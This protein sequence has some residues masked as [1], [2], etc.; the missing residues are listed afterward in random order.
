MPTAAPA[1]PPA[2]STPTAPAAP[3]IPP[4]APDKQPSD[5]MGDIMGD[6]D[7]LDKG[8]T[9]PTPPKAAPPPKP[10]PDAGKVKAPEAPPAPEKAPETPAADKPPETPPKPVR[11]AEL[12]TAYENLKKEANETLR[13]TIQRLEARVKELEAA[14]ADVKPLQEKL[15]AI[16]KRN[17]ELEQHL[18]FVDYSKSAEFQ[19]KYE[20][21]FASAWTRAVHDFSQLSV[22]IP[23]GE[24]D[25]G[26]PKFKTRAATADDLLALANMPLSQ[27]DEQA[28]AMFG[29]SAARVIN[30]VEKIRD[31]YGAKQKALDDA[32]KSASERITTGQAQTKA[33]HEAIVKQFEEATKA[34][35]TKYPTM[36]GPDESDPAGNALLQKG[37]DEADRVFKATDANRPKTAE[38]AI[39]LHARLRLK[40]ANHDRLALRLK[41]LRAELD[42]ARKTIAEYEGSEPKGGRAGDTAG[43]KPTYADPMQEV[44]AELKAMD[45]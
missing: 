2:P 12:R 18:Q 7:A 15:A 28:E 45:R 43:G 17:K 25:M 27:M 23:D 33:Q 42:E 3:T 16:E 13:P 19:E 39:R 9:P 6:L 5:Y 11:A 32:Q 38:E 34:D 14:P 29:R 37:L 35:I 44:E 8:G 30:H 26:N 4:S 10:A 31:L 22:R 36:F 24:D 41:K 21:P 40:A 1:A 20:Q